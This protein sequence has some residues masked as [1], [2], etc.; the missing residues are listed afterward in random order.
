M[1][2]EPLS[3]MLRPKDMEDFVGQT[4]I[5]DA[6]SRLLEVEKIPFSL[7]FFGPPGLEKQLMPT[8]LLIHISIYSFL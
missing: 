5:R 4:D 7:I 1:M 3:Y 8:F 6:L 2:N